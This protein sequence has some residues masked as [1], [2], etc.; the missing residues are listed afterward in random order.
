MKSHGECSVP[1]CERAANYKQDMICQ[2]HYFRRM[3]NGTFDLKE[4]KYQ[5]QGYHEHSNGYRLLKIPGHP[6][7]R[8]DGVIFEHRAVMF[9][10]HGWD[11][12]PCEKCGAESD[13]FTR[14][15]HIDHIDK[16]RT[17]N[18]PSNLRVLCNPCNVSRTEKIHH[19]YDHCLAV[20]VNGVTKTPTEWSREPGVEVTAATIRKRIKD[21]YS[22]HDAL[23]ARK[24]THNGNVRGRAAK[25]LN[26][27]ME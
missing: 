1:G 6:I 15:T 21:G 13:W 9:D 17:N 10:I 23:Y 5:K 26:T 8:K 24:I 7:A 19:S 12:P 27:L 20:T 3:R 2:M 11:L 25:K 16:D 14:K 22:H 18:N 4:T